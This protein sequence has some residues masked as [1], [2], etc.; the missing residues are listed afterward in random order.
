MRSSNI[1]HFLFISVSCL[2]FCPVLLGELLIRPT[3]E[4]KSERTS[5][6]WDKF[7][8]EFQGRYTFGSQKSGSFYGA[9]QKAKEEGYLYLQNLLKNH[10]FTKSDLSINFIRNR[11]KSKNTEYFSNGDV[12][13]SLFIDMRKIFQREYKNIS[14]SKPLNADGIPGKESK[15]ILLLE[16]KTDPKG[17]FLIKDENGNVLHSIHN[18]NR[19]AFKKRLM[20]KWFKYP[21]NSYGPLKD[22]LEAGKTKVP[23]LLGKWDE[24]KGAIQIEKAQWVQYNSRL[25]ALLNNS[26]LLIYSP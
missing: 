2:F 10:K 5:L 9:D 6:R 20:G 1:K 14:F 3:V 16:N 26:K 23:Y 22:R 11:S 8:I 17:V 19:E 13:V 12:H 4:K 7:R 18:V 15:L 25:Q 24:N 21:K